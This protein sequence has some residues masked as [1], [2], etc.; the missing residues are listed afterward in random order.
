MLGAIVSPHEWFQ[1]AK[2]VGARPCVQLMRVLKRNRWIH[3]EQDSGVWT[4]IDPL[5][6]DAVLQHL[7]ETNRRASISGAVLSVLPKEN[8]NIQRRALLSYHAGDPYTALVLLGEAILVNILAVEFG[9]A[10]QLRRL[11]N[12]IWSR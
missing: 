9:Q 3:I 2:K 1:V 11:R 4:F 7:D 12:S 6:R 10:E 5:F 8:K